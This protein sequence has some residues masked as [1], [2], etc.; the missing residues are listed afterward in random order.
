MKKSQNSSN[1]GF[2][3]YYFCLMMDLDF[4][5]LANG[6]G[7]RRSKTKVRVRIHNTDKY[8]N[9]LIPRSFFTLFSLR[10]DPASLFS[11]Q[12]AAATVSYLH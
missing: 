3:Y 6:S 2:S 1:Q 10:S 11:M 8:I 9:F 4:I 5:H 7:S 12:K